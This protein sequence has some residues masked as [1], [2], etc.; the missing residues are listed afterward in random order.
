[1][2]GTH[3]TVLPV[4]NQLLDPGLQVLLEANVVHQVGELLTRVKLAEGLQGVGDLLAWIGGF[5]HAK[6]AGHFDGGYLNPEGNEGVLLEVGR[7]Q[8]VVTSN[9]LL[10]YFLNKMN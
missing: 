3:E 2:L 8:L 1:M 10:P 6:H 7:H 4:A 5:F 9:S